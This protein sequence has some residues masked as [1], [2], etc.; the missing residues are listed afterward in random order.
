[1]VDEDKQ[2][3]FDWLVTRRTKVQELTLEVY[4]VLRSKQYRQLLSENGVWRSIFALIAGAAFSLWRAVFL[5]V[6]AER[7]PTKLLDALEKFLRSVVADNAITYGDDKKNC[8]WTS[9]YYLNN[10]SY[11]MRRVVEKFEAMGASHAVESS[12]AFDKLKLLLASGIGQ[13][14]NLAADFETVHNSV[15]A[16][17]TL[18]VS[19]MKPAS[20][21]QEESSKGT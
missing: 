16:A 13:K 17:L 12:D 3:D 11:R 5:V 19:I 7:D 20:R 4:K 18:L 21:A 14:G 10:S 15:Q 8:V 2:P 9:G 6:S 1:M